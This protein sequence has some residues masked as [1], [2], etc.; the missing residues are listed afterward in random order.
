MGHVERVAALRQPKTMKVSQAEALGDLAG[1]SDAALKDAL[2]ERH[3]ARRRLYFAPAPAAVHAVKPQVTKLRAAATAKANRVQ[4]SAEPAADDAPSA[5][6]GC[7][8][9]PGHT[10]GTFVGSGNDLAKSLCRGAATGAALCNPTTLTGAAGRGKTHLLEATANGWRGSGVNGAYVTAE[11]FLYGDHVDDILSCEAVAMD[12][13]HLITS[14]K[15]AADLLRVLEVFVT[16]G[17]PVLLSMATVPGPGEIAEAVRSRIVGGIVVEMEAPDTAT[18]WAIF[19]AVVEQHQAADPDLVMPEDVATFVAGAVT[20]SARDVISAGNRLV[21]HHYLT[22]RPIDLRMAEDALRDLLRA[23]ESKRP[24]VE[25]IQRVVCQHF[26]VSREDLVS[27]R[28]TKVIVHPRQIAMYLS[29]TLTPRSLPEIGR[30]F[31]HRDHTTVLHAV[32]KVEA[33]IIKDE[34]VAEDVRVLTRL[35]V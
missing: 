3:R 16:L 26:N 18:R 33:L 30:R 7:P 34:Q 20:G 17:K 8:I 10:F 5:W 9:V 15:S 28:R 1:L 13:A 25:D 6:P 29:K 31:G 21:A 19:D 32:R 14:A 4:A 35:L 24:K 2:A 11:A 22:Q 12:D 23:R 27:A